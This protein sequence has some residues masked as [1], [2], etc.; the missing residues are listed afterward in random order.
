MPVVETTQPLSKTEEEKEM[1]TKKCS[2]CGKEK[3]LEEGFTKNRANKD[4]Y[5]YSCRQCK[6]DRLAARKLE[7]TTDKDGTGRKKRQPR[8]PGPLPSP[9]PVTEVLYMD[10]AAIRSI[11]RN[12]GKEILSEFTKF[13]ETRYA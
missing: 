3:D 1:S 5:E 4:G 6:A 12:V 13:L 7:R 8:N 2:T 10:P 11:K 9:T